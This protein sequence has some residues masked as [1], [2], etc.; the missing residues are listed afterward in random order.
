MALPNQDQ[1]CSFWTRVLSAVDADFDHS[2]VIFE[3]IKR[4][5]HAGNVCVPCHNTK[6]DKYTIVPVLFLG[7]ALFW[8]LLQVILELLVLARQCPTNSNAVIPSIRCC[9]A[10]QLFFLHDHETT[11]MFG[12]QVCTILLLTWTWSLPSLHQNLHPDK[13]SLAFACFVT[14]D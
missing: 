12:F 13:S 4:C 9:V 11:H 3:N 1:L 8:P 5:S 7:F 2:F 6:I 14:A 10:K